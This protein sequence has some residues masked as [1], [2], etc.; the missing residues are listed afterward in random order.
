MITLPKVLATYVAPSI[1]LPTT[2]YTVGSCIGTEWSTWKPM[3]GVYGLEG[4]FF[5]VITV[6]DGG[7]TFK[8]GTRENDWK[9]YDDVKTFDDQAGAG[10]S[11][12]DGNIKIDKAG[13]YTL[14]YECKI[15]GGK[16]VY[17][18]HV[19]PT[20]VYLI[21]AAA[22]GAWTDAD[23]NW[24]MT[25]QDGLWVTPAFTGG[26]EMRAYVKITGFDWWRTE[27][28]LLNGNLYWRNANIPNNWASDIGADYS[29]TCAVGQRLY[30]NFNTANGI[31]TGEVK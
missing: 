28:T 12:A 21:G 31:D 5:S 9:G 16:I 13:V 20:A 25:Q 10:L 4:K 1:S 24:A 8:W 29:V 11:N 15:A 23:P 26:G 19:Y 17:T 3:A 22:G 7:A 2:L 18:V 30:V 27:F 6:P 14:L